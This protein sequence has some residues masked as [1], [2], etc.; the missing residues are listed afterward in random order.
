M[1]MIFSCFRTE[2]ETCKTIHLLKGYT[3]SY[4]DLNIYLQIG[5]HFFQNSRRNNNI[6]D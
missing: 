4:S 2:T 3:D 5:L 1:K 6:N